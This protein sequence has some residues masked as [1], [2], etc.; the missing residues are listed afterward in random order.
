MTVRLYR[1]RDP[2]FAEPGSPK[3]NA[4]ITASKAAAIVGL[5]RWHS[6]YS[7]WLEMKGLIAP[8]PAKTIYD[9]GKAM[10]LALAELWKLRH[11]GC[12][13]SPTHVQFVTDDYGFDAAVTPDRVARGRGRKLVEMKIA[14]DWEGWGDVDT[15]GDAPTDYVVQNIFQ[16]GVSG[17]RRPLDLMVMGPWFSEKCYTIEWDETVWN[18]MVAVCQRFWNSLDNNEQPPLDDSISTYSAVR[19][20]HPDINQ[21]ESVEI[22]EALATDYL[23]A[24]AESKSAEAVLRGLKSK[25]LSVAGSA[26][27]IV[28]NGER[29]AARQPHFRGGVSLVAKMDAS[30]STNG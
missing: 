14:R 18:W 20:L 24:L 16:M 26:Q 23:A 4:M 29:V 22:P 9:T 11:P 5:S 8:E 6:A 10:E 21:G 17:I 25:I 28:C 3:H 19:A 1:P 15:P 27:Y 12:Q 7:C 13:L 30:Q 2:E